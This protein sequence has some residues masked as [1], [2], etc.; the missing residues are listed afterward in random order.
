VS[1]V[2]VNE[3]AVEDQVRSRS[4]I[5]SAVMLISSLAWRK[6]GVG[7]VTAGCRAPTDTQPGSWLWRRTRSGA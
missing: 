4:R 3:I 2:G 6:P 5:A 1:E 7:L